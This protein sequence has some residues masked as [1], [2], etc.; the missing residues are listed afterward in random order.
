MTISPAA[1]QVLNRLTP[2]V[3]QIKADGFERAAQVRALMSAIP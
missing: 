2:A 1:A 3:P